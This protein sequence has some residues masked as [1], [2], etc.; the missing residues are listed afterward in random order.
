MIPGS[1]FDGSGAPVTGRQP[2]GEKKTATVR[3][4]C[5]VKKASG[6]S[7]RKEKNPTTT[8]NSSS[9]NNK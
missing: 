3:R 2:D 6:S 8:I 1:A 4:V 7:E 9:N 5:N